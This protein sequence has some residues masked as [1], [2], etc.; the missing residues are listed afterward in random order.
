[1]VSLACATFGSEADEIAIRRRLPT[2]TRTPL[3]S[4]TPTA[5]ATQVAVAMASEPTTADSPPNPSS[6]DSAAHG[7]EVSSN[8]PEA[9][10][11]PLVPPINAY[12]TP[13]SATGNQNN[14][15][16]TLTSRVT[17]NVRSGPGL[18]HG[19]VGKL[20]VG[21]STGITGQN[22]DG[23]WWQIE[24]PSGSGQQAWVSANPQYSTVSQTMPQTIAQASTPTSQ[25][26]AAAVTA[27]SPLLTSA[28]PAPTPVPFPT[29]TAIPVDTPIP[30]PLPEDWVFAG[31]QLTPKLDGSG[32]L[33]HGNLLNNTGNAQ[34]LALVTGTFYDEQGQVVADGNTTD[35]WPVA[36]IPQGGQV[37]FELVVPGLT[38]VANFDLR[39]DAQPGGTIPRQ[40][41]EFFD[42]NAANTGEDYCVGGKL[43]NPGDK[44][45]SYLVIVAVIYDEQGN[46][47]N[48]YDL[49]NQ[50]PQDLVGD[51]TADFEI[52]VNPLNQQVAHFESLAWG[53]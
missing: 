43:R 18:D 22:P 15:Q 5:N 50:S 40:D 53:L 12:T 16:P 39:V 21:Q 10:S 44:L 29:E 33:V 38:S 41:F 48:Y 20:A 11:V 46:V 26:V 52:C 24:Y 42:L 2:L 51:Q 30:T 25:P 28:P 31:V 35:Y 6:A 27:T 17:L 9:T 23:S 49:Y 47:I 32:L 37:P 45:A 4:L 34:E 7:G 14:S 36:G 19:V 1:V 3:P 8:L 13:P